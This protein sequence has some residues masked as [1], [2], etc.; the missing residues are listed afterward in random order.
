MIPCEKFSLP[1]LEI[2]IHKCQIVKNV[3]SYILKL[4]LSLALVS[5]QTNTS[6]SFSWLRTPG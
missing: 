5:Q 1:S 2:F 6:S 4:V 3:T